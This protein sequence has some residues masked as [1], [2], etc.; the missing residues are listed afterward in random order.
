M[1]AQNRP[2]EVPRG[3]KKRHRKKKTEKRRKKEHQERQKEFQ[4]AL[5]PFDPATRFLRV[6]GEES[7]LVGR[8]P[9]GAAIFARLDKH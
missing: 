5:P 8:G 2:Q 9:Q 7:S 3:D 6:K 1:G 4:K